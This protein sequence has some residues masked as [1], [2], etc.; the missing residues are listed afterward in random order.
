MS[1]YIL[2]FIFILSFNISAKEQRAVFAGGCFWCMEPPFE[3]LVGVKSVIS[4]YSG[5]ELK[6]PTYEQVSSGKTK[7]LEAVQVIFDD[8]LVSYERLLEIFW[9]NIDPTDKGGQFVDRGYQYST[10]IFT[11][12]DVQKNKAIESLKNLKS[13]GKFK[14]EIVTPIID[15]K[16]FFKAEEYHQNYYK[17]SFLTK[18]K[19]KYYRAASGRDDFIDKYWK[20]GDTFTPTID[21]KNLKKK[22]NKMQYEV[23]QEEGTEPPFKNEFWNNKKEGLYVD[24]VSNEPLFSSLDKYK[25]GTGWPSFTK[26]LVANNIIEKV[27]TKL[28]NERVEVR[29]RL[30]DSHLGHVFKDGPAPTGLRY[31]LNSA[32]LKFIPLSEL[33]ANELGKYLE[34]FKK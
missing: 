5:G 14:K 24:I 32:S 31:C 21:K 9:Q 18:A 33:E 8:E 7:H 11:F 13:L 16:T 10:A 3:K 22:L 15:F 28:G 20:E 6:N 34:L 25:S 2:F 26:P 29:S 12:S 17:K 23:T 27:D 30:G 1:K 19:Y 4:G